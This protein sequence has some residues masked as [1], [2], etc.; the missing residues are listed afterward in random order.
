VTKEELLETFA[1]DMIA[2]RGGTIVF[3]MLDTPGRPVLCRY[4][5]IAIEV[6][7]DD[8]GMMGYV[9]KYVLRVIAA[10]VYELQHALQA[11]EIE[12]NAP[13]GRERRKVTIRGKHKRNRSCAEAT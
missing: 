2:I 5:H 6:P 11:Y 7:H 9:N 13:T 12:D 10:L 4:K 1:Q 8:I 3:D